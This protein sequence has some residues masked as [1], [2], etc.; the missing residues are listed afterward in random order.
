[1]ANIYFVP[2]KPSSGEEGQY[3]RRDVDFLFLANAFTWTW[4]VSSGWEGAWPAVR[5]R[6]ARETMDPWFLVTDWIT[7]AD[8]NY[9]FALD[10]P[11]GQYLA[12]PEVQGGIPALPKGFAVN[13]SGQPLP[14]TYVWTATTRFEHQYGQALIGA[15]RV[16]WPG[17]IP[18]PKAYPLKPREPA[19]FDYVPKRDQLWARRFGWHQ[20]AAHTRMWVRRKDGSLGIEADQKYFYSDVTGTLPASLDPPPMTM[21]DGEKY[22]GTL[23]FVTKGIV[24]PSGNGFY[25]MEANGRLGFAWN[26]GR[27]LTLAG[28][29]IK[30]GELKRHSHILR[31][32]PVTAKDVYDS[33]WETVGDW[34]RVPQPHA[35]AEGWGFAAHGDAGGNHEFWIPDTLSGRI[36]YVNHYTAHGAANYHL[37]DFP[38]PGYTAPEGPTGQTQL[39][40]YETWL[41]GPWDCDIYPDSRTTPDAYLYWTEFEGNSLSRRRLDGSAPKEVLVKCAI[42]PTD[43]QLGIVVSGR[44]KQSGKTAAQLRETYKIDGPAGTATCVRPQGMV[45]DPVRRRIIWAERYTYLLRYYDL[46]TAE[47]RTLADLP[48][49]GKGFGEADL[50]LA[51]SDGTFYPQGTIFVNCWHWHHYVYSPEGEY[52]DR[53][54]YTNNNLLNGPANVTRFP[55]YSWGACVGKGRLYWAGSAGGR[56]SVELTLRTPEDGTL[57]AARAKTGE[58]NW[59]QSL[60]TLTHGPMGQGELGFPTM[61]EIGSWDDDTIRAYLAQI[62]VSNA[63]DNTLYW[64]RH[65]T[66]DLLYE[67]AP[68]PPPPQD[69]VLSEWGPWSEWEIDPGDPTR[70][71]RMR[72]RTVVTEPANGGAECGPLIEYEYRPAAVGPTKDEAL[73]AL[74]VVRA[75]IEGA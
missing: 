68:P 63:N 17:E 5:M 12:W 45:I 24:S 64:I 44:L 14:D 4:R 67:A 20:H 42:D 32:N 33:A 25:F 46:D 8:N 56:Q 9:N 22:V 61:D 74:E 41:N 59:R 36:L 15:V 60:A 48:I 28:H 30:P 34:S 54:M 50:S 1:M 18:K 73:A 7:P 53:L 39:A 19:F 47:V 21:R 38:P 3:N 72:E 35:I 27:V 70:E 75:Y 13:A 69:C 23:G 62:G 49:G 16:D 52:I 58:D 40:V 2:N 29:R 71:V 31:E 57:D 51:I 11:D 66:R 55:N 65:E 10:L 37:P 43:A 6:I 26:T